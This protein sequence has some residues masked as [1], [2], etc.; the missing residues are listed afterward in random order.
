L[1]DVTT[2]GEEIVVEDQLCQVLATD[3]SGSLDLIR[4][5]GIGVVTFLE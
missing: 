2:S 1:V 5:Q 3:Y 4:G